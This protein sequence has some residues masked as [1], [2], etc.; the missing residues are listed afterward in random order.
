MLIREKKDWKMTAAF[1]L[2]ILFNV[3]HG[4]KELFKKDEMVKFKP[5]SK[6]PPLT[7]IRML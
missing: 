4:Y 6:M 1:S 5:Y 7:W 3:Y 2:E